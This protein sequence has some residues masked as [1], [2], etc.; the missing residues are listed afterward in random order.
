MD[1]STRWSASVEY[2]NMKERLREKRARLAQELLSLDPLSLRKLEREEI[3]KS[4]LSWLLGPS[5]TFQPS[6]IERLEPLAFNI[7]EESWYN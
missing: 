5:F 6:T 3:M 4:V 2:D 1:S 7:D